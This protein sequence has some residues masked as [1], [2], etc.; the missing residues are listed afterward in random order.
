MVLLIVFLFSCSNHIVE[1]LTTHLCKTIEPI[2]A[3][4]QTL[5]IADDAIF[6]FRGAEK[7][8]PQQIIMNYGCKNPSNEM[9]AYV[10]RH[11]HQ[12]GRLFLDIDATPERLGLID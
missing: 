10:D 11:P 6:R 8:N 9:Y 1:E 12:F 4:L 7:E 3:H 2:S 5:V